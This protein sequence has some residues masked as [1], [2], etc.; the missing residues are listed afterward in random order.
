MAFKCGPEHGN[1]KYTDEDRR[2]VA[3][4]FALVGNMRRVSKVVGIPERTLTD[5]R[6]S[7]WFDELLEEVRSE[8]DDIILANQERIIEMAHKELADRIQGGDHHLVK[9]GSDYEVK[10]VPVKAKD[11]AVIGGVAYDKRRLSLNKP[12]SISA[13][14]MGQFDKFVKVMAEFEN[15]HA[16][17]MIDGEWE[18]GEIVPQA[19]PETA[20]LSHSRRDAGPNSEE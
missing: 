6:R 20:Q 14:G 9:V 2:R 1:S 18:D 17:A 4:E 7:E 15:K 3:V 12:T 19:T 8:T 13:N 5:W 11:L 16:K 10:R